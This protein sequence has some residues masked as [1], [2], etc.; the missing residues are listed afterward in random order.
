[1]GEQIEIVKPPTKKHHFCFAKHH[2]LV[3]GLSAEVTPSNLFLDTSVSSRRNTTLEAYVSIW[4]SSGS[5][6]KHGQPG[7]AA[8][9]SQARRTDLLHNLGLRNTF[10]SK[11]IFRIFQNLILGSMTFWDLGSDEQICFIIWRR[12]IHLLQNGFF[13]F[14][15]TSSEVV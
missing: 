8:R 14:S 7:Q 3:R 13:V 6:K 15:R 11:W 1:M 4:R 2:F 10:A 12:Q 9:G 5:W